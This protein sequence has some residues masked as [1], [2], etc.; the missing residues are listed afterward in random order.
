[1]DHALCIRSKKL[2]ALNGQTHEF[3]T[4]EF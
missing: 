1:V 2:V 4:L 3:G